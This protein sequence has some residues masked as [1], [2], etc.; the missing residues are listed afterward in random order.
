MLSFGKRRKNKKFEESLTVTCVLSEGKPL[1]LEVLS[2]LNDRMIPF[3]FSQL[4]GLF[5]L[6]WDFFTGYM[7]VTRHISNFPSDLLQKPFGN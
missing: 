4:S 3:G 1:T 7:G 2:Y 5:G 6:G